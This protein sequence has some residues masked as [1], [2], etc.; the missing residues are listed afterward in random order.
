MVGL[1]SIVSVL[2]LLT[3][4]AAWGAGMTFVLLFG[5]RMS[6]K[7]LV[8]NSEMQD[9]YEQRLQAYRAEIARLSL[10]IEQS[11]FD[12]TSVEGR[13]VEMGRRQR[14]ID[15][16][17]QALKRLADLIGS[18]TGAGIPTLTPAP[19]TAQPPN[20]ITFDVPAGEAGGG[21]RLWRENDYREAATEPG[22]LHV[23]M[24]APPVVEQAPAQAS[25]EIELFLERMDR[26]LLGAEQ[27]QMQVLNMLGRSFDGRIERTRSAIAMVGLTPEAVLQW[28]GRQEAVLPNI[29]LPL[30]EQQTAFGQQIGRVRQNFAILYGFKP[31]VESLP[32]TRP[33]ATDVR[34]SSGFGYRIHPLMGTR[35]L[36][37]GIDM[38]AP[39]GTTIRAAGSGTVVSAGW[40]GGYGNL[41]QIEH[42]NGLVTRY[43]HLSQIDVSPRQPIGRGEVIGR[44]GSTGASTGSHLHFETRINGNPVNPACF[45]LAGDRILGTQSI[46]YNCEQPPVW[47]LRKS[48][49]DEDDDS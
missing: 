14:Q 24:G 13:V 45:I 38:A 28:R 16:R 7:L 22:L 1:G 35:R 30:S 27:T 3:L 11:R 33:T 4:L 43:A 42:G 12:Q 23:Q 32:V 9:T 2:V 20:R 44:M 19:G 34:Y 21:V 40:G 46:P 41:V 10:E 37:A 8:Q 31:L 17:L 39:V 15:A 48:D 26:V 25:G 18:A 29:V 49:E 47:S 6:E 5:D 36:H